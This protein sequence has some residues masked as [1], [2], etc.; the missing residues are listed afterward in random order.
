MV[1]RVRVRSTFSDYLVSAATPEQA[2]G[3]ALKQHEEHETSSSWKPEVDVV[4]EPTSKPE[5]EA[6]PDD[7]EQDYYMSYEGGAEALK[8]AKTEPISS[9]S[10]CEEDIVKCLKEDGFS[11]C[12]ENID[13]VAD[14]YAV[15]NFG[16]Y[17]TTW[18]ETINQGIDE[19][20]KQLKKMTR[21]EKKE[22]KE[23]QEENE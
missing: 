21:E 1:Y 11:E 2:I 16:E 22:Y 3:A 13:L 17:G 15:R 8:D 12:P 9:T 18:D 10:I 7:A 14:T 20:R 19:V 23:E 5:V 4:E 6:C